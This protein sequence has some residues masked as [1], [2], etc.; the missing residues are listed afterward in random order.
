[1]NQCKRI[2]GEKIWCVGRKVTKPKLIQWTSA[3]RA[4]E[5][6]VEGRPAI[7]VVKKDW[8]VLKDKLPDSL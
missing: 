3:H 6:V 4:L 1:M 8:R 2:V 5:V 7:A